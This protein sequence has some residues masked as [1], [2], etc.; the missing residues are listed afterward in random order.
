MV[1]HRLDVAIELLALRQQLVE[2]VLA[3]DCAQRR[4]R[5]LAGRFV[6]VRHLDDRELRL[7][8]PEIHDRVHLHRDVIA[9]DHVL[10]RH[11]EHPGSQIDAH[12][13]LDRW[14]H[15]DQP[16][17]LHAAEAAEE[18]DHPALVLAQN[19]DRRDGQ[20]REQNDDAA[21]EIHISPPPV[22]RPVPDP[23]C[24]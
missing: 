15:E 13:L 4:L 24:L 2:L 10:R 22:R 7:H 20:K 11:V 12:H 23:A 3:K 19:L 1:Q 14:H 8:Y 17:P 21:D 16:R 5:E 9:G 18:E 6:E